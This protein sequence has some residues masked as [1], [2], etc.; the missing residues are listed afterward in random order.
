MPFDVNSQT[1]QVRAL[2]SQ[3]NATNAQNILQAEKQMA[4]QEAS[5]A[6]AM[7]FSADQARINREWQ[8]MMS[9]TAHQREVKDLIAAGL[10]PILAANGG[11]STPS[12]STASGVNSAGAM[13]NIESGASSMSSLFNAFTNSAATMYSAET[14]AEAAVRSAVINSEASKY[15]AEHYPNSYAGIISRLADGLTGGLTGAGQAIANFFNGLFENAPWYETGKE[16]VRDA[17]KPNIIDQI[18]DKVRSD[19]QNASMQKEHFD[20]FY[21]YQRNPN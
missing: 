3:I 20:R 10:N 19:Q 11:A 18:A 13:A 21:D 6:K 17:S 2:T 9:N 12:G 15:I 14:S 7:N 16:G 5:N 4:F 8:E 1:D